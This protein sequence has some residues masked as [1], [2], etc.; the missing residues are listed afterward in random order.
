MKSKVN[1]LRN[2]KIGGKSKK[3]MNDF[4]KVMLKAKKSKSPSFKYK[5]H[6]YKG[7]KHN[8]LGM[9]YKKA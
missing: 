8:L 3:K 9:I 4:F 7:V 2:R 1:K 5:G 6:V